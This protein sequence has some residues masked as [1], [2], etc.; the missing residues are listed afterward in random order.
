MAS[1][2]TP[3]TPEEYEAAKAVL[4]RAH[5]AGVASQTGQS[6]S[7]GGSMS[8]ASKRLRDQ[9]D[10]EL[11]EQWE[12]VAYSEPEKPMCEDRLNPYKMNDQKPIMS[13]PETSVVLPPG[14]SCI[15]DWST[16][17]CRLPKVQKLGM[18]YAELVASRDH[19]GYLTWIQ[20]HGKGRG[21]KFE[22]LACYL[23]AIRFADSKGYS[24]D[25]QKTDPNS[26]E[27]REKR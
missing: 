9:R 27:K 8:D 18:T 24:S 5:R 4:S 12:P 21:G 16:T 17:I 15:A 23:E 2:N 19:H 11:D 10:I 25:P 20:Q 26:C 22:D 1:S 6:S 13:K 3:V 7:T 14:I